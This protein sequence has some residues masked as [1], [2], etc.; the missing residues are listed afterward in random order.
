MIVSQAFAASFLDDWR[1]PDESDVTGDWKIFRQAGSE[2]YTVADDFNGDGEQDEAWILIKKD[3]SEWG[4][5][6][7]M[8]ANSNERKI[9]ELGRT[10]MAHDRPQSMGIGSVPPGHYLSA[11]AKGYGSGCEPGERR[12]VDLEYP[13]I[14]FFIFESASSHFFWNEEINGFERIW[15]SD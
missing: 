8:S 3:N 13:A 15:I 10:E 14:D 12:F 1:F 5:F 4:L 2:F 9:I 6:V 7:L 11:C